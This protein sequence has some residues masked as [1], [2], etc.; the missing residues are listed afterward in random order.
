VQL[1][2]VILVNGTSQN[3]HQL[4]LDNLSLLVTV[5]LDWKSYKRF[6]ETPKMMEYMS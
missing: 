1:K 6:A 2:G 3:F 4:S 5:V